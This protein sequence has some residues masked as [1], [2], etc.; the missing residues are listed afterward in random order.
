[1]GAQSLAET[2]SAAQV[3]AVGLKANLDKL[4]RRGLDEAFIGS[5]DDLNKSLTTLNAEQEAL[6]SRLKEKTAQID[7]A[8]TELKAKT[9]EA[10]KVVKLELGQASWREFGI[11]DGR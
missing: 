11:T 2:L 1:M 9:S 5:I 4:K 6:K 3:L 7:G 8:L 10:R